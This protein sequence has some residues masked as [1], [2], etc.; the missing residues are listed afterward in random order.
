[1]I[2]RWSEEQVVCDRDLFRALVEE[3]SR[4]RGERGR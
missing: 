2:E 1:M 3:A 4:Y